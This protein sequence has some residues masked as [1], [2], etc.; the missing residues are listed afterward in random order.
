MANRRTYQYAKTATWLQSA[1]LVA[2]WQSTWP[3]G[4]ERANPDCVTNAE[5][6]STLELMFLQPLV[7]SK[8]PLRRL[9]SVLQHLRPLSGAR[10]DPTKG[11]FEVVDLSIYHLHGLNSAASLVIRLSELA[12]SS[13]PPFTSLT[14]STS[15]CC[16]AMRRR[17]SLTCFS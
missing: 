12:M 6:S 1:W 2:H 14:S 10:L 9:G 16:S 7:T 4:W 13:I 5:S 17:C 15:S 8:Q 3:A 11:F